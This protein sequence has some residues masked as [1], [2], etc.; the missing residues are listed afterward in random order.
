MTN[1]LLTEE[2]QLLRRTVRDF[3]ERELA[4]RAA[5]YDEDETFPWENVRAIASMGLFG[6]GIDPKYG[7]SGGTVRQ[8]AIAV[9][10]LA[11]GCAATS[12]IYGAHLSLATQM[13]HTLG[14]EGQ[15]QR[16]VPKMASG[17]K[18]GAFALT[19]AGG[20]SDVA[21]M[22]TRVAK[23]DG[24][25]VL[26]GAKS[27]ITNGD[28]ADVLI[29][30]ATHDKSLRSKGISALIV[31]GD[32]RGLTVNKQHGK[33]GIRAASTAELVFEDCEVPANNLLGQE[34]EGF[35]GAMRVLDVS[36][37]MIAAQA[38]GIAQAAFDVTLKY[39]QH[40]QVFGQV[41]SGFQGIQWEM[42]ETATSIDAARLMT[43]HAATLKDQG[44]AFATQASMAKLL[45]SEVAVRAADRAVQIHGGYGYFKPALAE[46][47]YRDAKITQI[48]EGTTEIQKLV[49]AR[50]IL[51]AT[52]N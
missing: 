9:E 22:Q 29:V 35:K 44:H 10:E 28:V 13:I 8:V 18:L 24:H 52:S 16:Y 38:V 33:M 15:R 11:R 46:R 23:R 47:L 3:A 17:E 36:R 32:A 27:F 14:D 7:G 25:Y 26:N 4:P 31:D 49:I 2:E 41:L 21:S 20:G 12:G 39:A 43:Y 42:A 1:L 5:Q 34:M 30:F 19:E 51:Q 6:L 40:R 48:Y 45:G 50:N 37:V